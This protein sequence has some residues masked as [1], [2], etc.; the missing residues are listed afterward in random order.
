MPQR[1]V[2]KTCHSVIT[3]PKIIDHDSMS[4]A[5]CNS[6]FNANPTGIRTDL[7]FAF[8]SFSGIVLRHLA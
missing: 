8:M 1:R 7:I 6:V 5:T 3:E 2:T 4:L